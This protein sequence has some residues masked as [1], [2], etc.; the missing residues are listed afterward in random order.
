MEVEGEARDLK[1]KP[2]SQKGRITLRIQRGYDEIHQR[3]ELPRL[4]FNS[5]TGREILASWQPIFKNSSV[6]YDYFTDSNGF[7]MVKRKVFDE[8]DEAP[9]ASTFYPIDS[10]ISMSDKENVNSLTIWNDRPQAGTVHYDG[11]MKLLIDRRTKLKDFGGLPETMIMDIPNNLVLHFRV[12]LH[13][14]Q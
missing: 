7:E 10:V 2:N 14:S 4:P 6:S 9:F 12:K 8:V 5:L 13:K 11:R 1:Y 3:I